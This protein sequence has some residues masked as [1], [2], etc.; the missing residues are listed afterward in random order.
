MLNG[1]KKTS[2]NVPM[3]LLRIMCCFFIILLHTSG[4][5]NIS[6]H[7]W[8]GIQV[9]V[10]PALWTFMA[11][12]GYF[13]F[14]KPIDNYLKFWFKHIMGLLI[15]V[16]IYLLFYHVFITK[17]IEGFDPFIFIK[18][19]PI[20][21][22]WYV[23]ALIQIYVLL[24]FLKKMLDALDKK[25]TIALLLTILVVT[26]GIKL[27]NIYGI[28][29]GFSVDL[30]GNCN[31]F[32]VILGYYLYKYPIKMK[33]KIYSYLLL[34][35]NLIVSYYALSNPKL[36]QGLFELSFVMTI[37]VI[38]FITIFSQFKE[39][40]NDDKDSIIRKVPGRIISFVGKRTFGIYIIHMS[41]FQYMTQ[42]GILLLNSE[43]VLEVAGILILK[44]ILIFLIGLFISAVLDGTLV[45]ITKWI[46]NKIYELIEKLFKTI[47]KKYTLIKNEN[48]TK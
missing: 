14:R 30:I 11:L 28:K 41:I 45:Y 42:N 22:L 16:T 36:S 31:L 21:H 20:G 6:G 18:G 29:V 19:D 17:S 37:G 27:L 15:P 35:I 47:Y 23:Y 10:R 39:K 13:A 34:G 26:R 9:I 4:H 48:L 46:F 24:P 7:L 43:N 33:R 8:K 1:E 44:T 3:D 38:C 5:L 32:F 40:D 12:T 25:Q 2:R